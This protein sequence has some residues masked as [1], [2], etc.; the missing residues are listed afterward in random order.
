MND[1]VLLRIDDAIARV[2]LNR[3]QVLNALDSDMVDG[4]TE[5]FERI[6]GAAG[7]RVVV[8]TGSGAGFM[9]GGDIR[10][11]Q[12]IMHL[13][14]AEKRA[15][16]E[17]FIHRVHPVVIAMR[18]LPLPIIAGVHGAVAGIG[19]SLM[20][21]CD[22]AL[23]ADD[24]RFTL[25]YC[26][27]GTSPDGGSTFFLP[28]HVG[29]KKA[30]EIALLGDRFDAA[31]ALRLGLVNDVVPAADLASRIGDLAARLAR[32]PEA[33]YAATK[34]LLNRSASVTIETQLQ[35]EAESFA[36]CAATPDFSEGVAAFIGKR[37]AK[38]S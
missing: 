4:L 32:G 2:T 19:M 11:F 1:T 20:M 14:P 38:F 25:A 18:R 31:T 37:P 29:S 10:Q 24:A 16:F 17:R 7:L 12:E 35:A 34:R 6:E 30:M 27:L 28:R 9:A 36:S 3:P 15:F 21:A 8:L 33:A 23:A 22:L 5:A 26:H 13:S